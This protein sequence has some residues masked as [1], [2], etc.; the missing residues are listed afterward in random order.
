MIRAMNLTKHEVI[1]SIVHS[2]GYPQKEVSDVVQKTLDTIA[3][4]LADGRNVEFR[5]FGVLELQVRK[6]RMGRNPNRPEMKVL[7][8]LRAVVKFKAG[9]DLKARLLKLDLA[10]LGKRGKQADPAA[11]T[12]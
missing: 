12:P 8:P 1:D 7:I 10:K 11:P 5:Q 4:A 6:P 3:A 2:T 9:K